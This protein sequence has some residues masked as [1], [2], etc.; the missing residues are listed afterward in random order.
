MGKLSES[1]LSCREEKPSAEVRGVPS[2]GE[3][4]EA[5]E[6]LR[7]LRA[8]SS[9]SSREA[10]AASAVLAGRGGIVSSGECLVESSP[11]T[12]SGQRGGLG[13]GEGM[14][15]IVQGVSFAGEKRMEGVR[16]GRALLAER[17]GRTGDVV[18][19][20]LCLGLL[21][22]RRKGAG[23]SRR[24]RRRQRRLSA[25]RSEETEPGETSRATTVKRTL[26]LSHTRAFLSPAERETMPAAPSWGRRE[27]EDEDEEREEVWERERVCVCLCV[28]ERLEAV[29]ADQQTSDER[30]SHERHRNPFPKQFHPCRAND[31]NADARR[32]SLFFF[33]LLL[34]RTLAAMPLHVMSS[35]TGRQK[36]RRMVCRPLFHSLS[37]D[38]GPVQCPTYNLQGEREKKEAKKKATNLE[39]FLL[40]GGD[41]GGGGLQP[42]SG[43]CLAASRA[44]SQGTTGYNRT[45]QDTEDAGDAKQS[46]LE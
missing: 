9:G 40:F 44:A 23:G 41:G 32:R 24:R 2:T 18:R 39:I 31:N 43:R 1:R 15:S 20:R 6:E 25:R 36:S 46:Q 37:P 30:E 28:N 34:T 3:G 21:C 5:V 7:R 35:Q 33:F 42:I 8:S 38:F 11:E 29:T 26:L 14:A 45:G 19:L 13:T 16:G 22:A 27:D 17:R 10:M 4:C 12:G